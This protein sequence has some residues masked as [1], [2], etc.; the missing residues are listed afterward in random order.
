MSSLLTFEQPTSTL[1]HEGGPN[2]RWLSENDQRN[3]LPAEGSRRCIFLNMFLYHVDISGSLLTGR[4]GVMSS[5]S[6][7]ASPSIVEKDSKLSG[8]NIKIGKHR[9]LI[10][11]KIKKMLSYKMNFSDNKE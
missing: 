11:F 8:L 4:S 2:A 6:W 7:A 5:F 9:T 3:L 10:I 1:R